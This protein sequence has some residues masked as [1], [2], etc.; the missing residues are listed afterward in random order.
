MS[1]HSWLRGRQ[2][3]QLMED[4]NWGQVGWRAVPV[5]LPPQ[6]VGAYGEA[7]LTQRYGFWPGLQLRNGVMGLNPGWIALGRGGVP[8]WQLSQTPSNAP[9]GQ[10]MG[11]QA[12]IGSLGIIKSRQL[13]GRVTMAQIQQS[14]LQLTQWAQELQGIQRGL[15]PPSGWIS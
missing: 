1:W 10:R 8:Y 13:R 14:G 12:Q 7:I 5:T 2:P 11:S 3:T 15:I 4:T 9:G 6:Q